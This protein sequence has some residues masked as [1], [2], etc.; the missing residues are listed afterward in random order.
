MQTASLTPEQESAVNR[1]AHL[2]VF[3]TEPPAGEPIDYRKAFPGGVII[4]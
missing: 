1:G 2:A 4:L 3:G